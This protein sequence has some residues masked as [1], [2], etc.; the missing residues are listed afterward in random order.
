MADL[1]NP[2][3]AGSFDFLQGGNNLGALCVSDDYVYAGLGWKG[4]S[5]VDVHLP[6]KP[7]AVGGYDTAGEVN[8]IW[9]ENHYAYL[10]EGWEGLEVFNASN[11]AQPF[12]IGRVPM[13]GASARSSSVWQLCLAL[14]RAAAV[15]PS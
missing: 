9:V 15:W 10:A 8:D 13:R 1:K 14:P 7:V 3:K 12:P 11:P 5:I 2:M 6:A 4:F